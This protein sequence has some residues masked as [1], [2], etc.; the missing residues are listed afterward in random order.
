MNKIKNKIIILPI[1]T[2]FLS[3]A[4]MLSFNFYSSKNATKN[5]NEFLKDLNEKKVSTVYI[6][7]TSTIKVKLNSNEIYKTDNPRSN[8]FKENLL[9]KGVKISENSPMTPQEVIPLSIFALSILSIIFMTIKNSNILKNK[10]LSSVDSLDTD[11]VENINLNFDSIAGNEEAKESVKD[12]V[13]F[14]KNPEKYSSYG[15][16]MP[17]GIILYGEP[18]TGKTLM[19]KAVAGEAG[20][21]FYAMS[22]SDFVQVYVGVGASRI[23]QLFKKARSKGKAVI[24]IDEIDA[25]GKKRSSEKSGGSEE[26]DQTLNALLT[27][28]SGFNEKEGIIVMAAT[29]R[30]DILD[31]A[32]LRPGRFDRHIE[33]NLPDVV[34]REKIFNLHLKNKPIGNVNIKDWAKK[35]AYFSG[36]KIEN[37]LN[38]A[39]ILACKENSV[40]IE[41]YHVDKAFSIVLAGYEKQNRAYIKNKDKKITA[42]HEIGHA[43]ISS[44]VL[45][46][47]KISKVTIIPSTKGAGGYTLS[48]PE[49]SLYQSKEYLINRIMVLLG[50]RVAE[51]IIFGKDNITTGAHNDL[52]KSTSIAYKMV[53]EYGMGETLGLLNMGS[54]KHE[55]SINENDIIKECKSL[56]DNIYIKV[57]DILLKEKK[58]LNILSEKLLE[59]ET[60]YEE[61]FIGL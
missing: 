12:I 55:L 37:L 3:I 35:T 42:Y 16:R 17:K 56:V 2:A 43:L 31:E 49:D 29:N 26:R 4:V 5:Y 50:G 9:K 33:I 34:A 61:D 15:A 32:L 36:A 6:T 24:F 48:I 46:N 14:L 45:P 11:E 57:K 41:D 44:I 60:L 39:A 27:E 10:K 7:N 53:T 58:Q 20:V 52:Q 40:K 23:R 18:G 51:E 19:A 25:I 8:D 1:L 54:L 13:D 21:P 22:G 28:M 38:E 30:L 47:E 59:K